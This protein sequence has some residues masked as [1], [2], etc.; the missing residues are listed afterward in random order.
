MSND[1]TPHLLFPTCAECNRIGLPAMPG[2]LRDMERDL[3]PHVLRAF[4]MAHG[5]REYC[6][7]A[8]VPD[9]ARPGPLGQ[10]DDWMRA[11]FGAGRVNIPKGPAAQSARLA[12]TIFTRLAA[13]WSLARIAEA[14]GCHTRT[15]SQRKKLFLDLGV[16]C[17]GRLPPTPQPREPRP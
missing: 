16:L 14:T 13:G 5:G 17:P 3:G 4:L 1:P 9:T 12:W 11:R 8:T 15:V 10:A 6:V 7:R 2:T